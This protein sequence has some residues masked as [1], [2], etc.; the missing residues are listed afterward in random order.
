MIKGRKIPWWLEETVNRE[1]FK[2][3]LTL[4][5]VALDDTFT[6]V[7]LASADLSGVI[8]HSLVRVLHQQVSQSQFQSSLG[9]QLV[10]RAN[11]P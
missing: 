2:S 6:W 11:K 4:T 7:F 8:Q 3:R 9:G 5:L 1:S 10:K